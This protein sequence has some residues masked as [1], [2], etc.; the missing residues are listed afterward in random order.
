M[1]RFRIVV[2]ALLVMTMGIFPASA[3]SAPAGKSVT[4][5][6]IETSDIHGAIYPYDF[7]N[8]KPL[9]TSLA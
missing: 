8:A 3:Q 2:L 6:F 1:K 9:A 7:V 4:L 5:T